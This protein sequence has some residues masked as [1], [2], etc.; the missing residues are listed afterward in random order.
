MEASFFGNQNQSDDESSTE[1]PAANVETVI[2]D[3][4]EVAY[5]FSI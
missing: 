2:E 3:E 4:V 5:S 1:S